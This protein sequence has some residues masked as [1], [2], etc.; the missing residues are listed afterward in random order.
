MASWRPSP[1]EPRCMTRR[2]LGQG[3]GRHR[4]FA[5]Y[6]VF[7]RVAPETPRSASLGSGK[8]VLKILVPWG[9]SPQTA[10]SESWS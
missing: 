8:R 5:Q 4:V 10:E 7:F 9:H 2:M 1:A 6:C 3:N